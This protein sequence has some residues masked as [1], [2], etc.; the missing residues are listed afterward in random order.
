MSPAATIDKNLRSTM[1]FAEEVEL[2]PS[3]APHQEQDH[4]EE[5]QV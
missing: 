3:Q 4:R 2:V 5:H 1:I